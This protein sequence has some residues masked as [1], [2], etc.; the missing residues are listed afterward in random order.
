MDIFSEEAPCSVHCRMC[1]V[2]AGGMEHL[3][4]SGFSCCWNSQA[5]PKRF[6]QDIVVERHPEHDVSWQA[7]KRHMADR[8]PSLAL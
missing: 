3:F 5:N 7:T 1:P 2:P 6:K 8:Q 4:Q